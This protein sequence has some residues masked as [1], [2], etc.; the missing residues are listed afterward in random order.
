MS[1]PPA[2]N[3]NETKAV[4]A[5]PAGKAIV[6][7]RQSGDPLPP[8]STDTP[9]H[10]PVIKWPAAGGPDDKKIPYKNCK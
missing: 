3:K 8:S 10:P 1:K 2:V 6:Q 7:S 4:A 9:D 5:P